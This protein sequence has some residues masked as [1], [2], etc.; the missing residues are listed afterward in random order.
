MVRDP[1]GNRVCKRI[2]RAG[3]SWA[4]NVWSGGWYGF[5]TNLRRYYYA[6]R[7]QARMAD[8]SDGIGTRGRVA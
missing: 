1:N 6:T 2:A 3:N 5:A 8:I 7:E 4:V